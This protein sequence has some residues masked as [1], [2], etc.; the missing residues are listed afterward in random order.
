MTASSANSLCDL[1]SNQRLS[2]HFVA[3]LGEFDLL[4]NTVVGVGLDNSS[5]LWSRLSLVCL[6]GRV[7]R[8]L[9]ALDMLALGADFVGS[10]G[11]IALVTGSVDAHTNRFFDAESL[12][13]FVGGQE[14]LDRN[15][16]FLA[17][18]THTFSIDF[19]AFDLGGDRTGGFSWDSGL[20]LDGFAEE[21]V[22]VQPD[23]K[24]EDIRNSLLWRHRGSFRRGR[25][26]FALQ[27]RLHSPHEFA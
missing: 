12:L 21:L 15:L 20:G 25:R 22:R 11:G 23:E 17:Q 9:L 13:I 3:G 10:E 24:G 8:A 27:H 14:W 26:G 2:T 6:L 5:T 19:G 18:F 7:T 16:E 1:L 4:A